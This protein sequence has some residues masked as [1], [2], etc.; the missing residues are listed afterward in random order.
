MDGCDYG[1]CLLL[2]SPCNQTLLASWARAG[3]SPGKL[4]RATYRQSLQLGS[5]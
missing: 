1:E 3:V 4:D 5:G 2:P